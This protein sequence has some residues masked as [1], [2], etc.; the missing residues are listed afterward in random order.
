MAV[1]KSRISTIAP[2][3]RCSIALSPYRAPIAL[4]LTKPNA[5]V[6]F[7]T[8][9]RAVVQDRIAAVSSCVNLLR[10]QSNI[11]G[12]L[13]Q[14][15]RRERPNDASATG[16]SPVASRRIQNLSTVYCLLMRCQFRQVLAQFASSLKDEEE[17]PRNPVLPLWEFF[18][19]NALSAWLEYS[20]R[21]Q[22][23]CGLLNGATVSCE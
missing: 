19:A 12:Q 7:T 5:H 17:T 18:F 14:R 15:R 13:I 23:L 20:D 11:A 21:F 1:C 3:H 16:Q 9:H 10:I 6:I 8:A 4:F 22:R 2:L